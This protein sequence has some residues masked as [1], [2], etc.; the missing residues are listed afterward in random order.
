MV[1]LLCGLEVWSEIKGEKQCND[2]Q[3]KGDDVT[4]NTGDKTLKSKRAR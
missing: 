4:D 3:F 1:P 2:N